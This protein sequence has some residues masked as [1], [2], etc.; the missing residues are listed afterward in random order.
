M[1]PPSPASP[2]PEELSKKEKKKKKKEKKAKEAAESGG[3]Q[4]EVVRNWVLPWYSPSMGQRLLSLLNA[5]RTNASASWCAC[6]PS[7]RLPTG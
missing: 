6:P 1:S 3:E 7:A 4:R 2:P 5:F